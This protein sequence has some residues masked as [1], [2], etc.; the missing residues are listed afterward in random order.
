MNEAKK[1]DLEQKYLMVDSEYFNGVMYAIDRRGKGM[2]ILAC[3]KS[4]PVAAENIMPFAA[5][6]CAVWDSMKPRMVR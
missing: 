1:A 6:I 3:G 4:I 5:E 2:H